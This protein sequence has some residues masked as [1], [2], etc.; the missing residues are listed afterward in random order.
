MTMREPRNWRDTA[1]TLSPC[2]NCGREND[3]A[4]SPEGFTP[5]PGDVS[6]CLGCAATLVF[7]EDFSTRAMTA[8]EWHALEDD[9]REELKLYRKGALL[10]IAERERRQQLN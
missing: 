10:A 2:P 4:S 8:A 6:V 9:F 7:N 1:I 5:S 3:T